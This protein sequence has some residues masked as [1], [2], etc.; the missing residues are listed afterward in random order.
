MEIKRYLHFVDNS[1]L[2]SPGSNGYDH[3]G[4]MGPVLEHLSDNSLLCIMPIE[5]VY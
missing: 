1:T 4:K 2:T 3:L 5:T